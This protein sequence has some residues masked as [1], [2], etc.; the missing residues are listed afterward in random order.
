MNKMKELKAFRNGDGA[1]CGLS[2]WYEDGEAELKAALDAH[3]PF[4]TGWYSSKKEI[5]A[6]RIRSED[7][8]TI[9]IDVSVSDDLETE[10]SGYMSITE[11]TLDAVAQAIGQAWDKADKD[12][13]DNAPYTGFSLMHNGRCIEYYLL[14]DG[15]Y[16]TPPGDYYHWWGWQHDELDG[17]DL[18]PP[19]LPL[20]AAAAFEN[21]ARRWAHGLT[22]DASCV[23]GAW[24]LQPWKDAKQFAY[25]DPNNYVGMGWVGQDGRP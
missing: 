2:D 15:T 10:G 3:E 24:S 11:W 19:D 20:P 16:D 13:E 14:G 4:D 18:P 21:W 7:G 1:H 8:V 9:K 25:E 6:A 23:I 17:Q 12:Q 22:K 5:A